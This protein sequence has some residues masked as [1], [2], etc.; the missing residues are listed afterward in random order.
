MQSKSTATLTN[1][2]ISQRISIPQTSSINFEN[3]VVDGATIEYYLISYIS[4]KR[5]LITGSL[6][7]APKT[8]FINSTNAS[9]EPNDGD[10]FIVIQAK[11]DCNNWLGK[12]DIGKTLFTNKLCKNDYFVKILDENSF[13]S[14]VMNIPAKPVEKDPGNGDG[15]EDEGNKL[16][17]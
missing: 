14:M 15:E 2:K 7:A 16:I 10:D 8:I 4:T 17:I 11:F 3:V 12:L 13:Q 1:A 6:G 9:G 5:P